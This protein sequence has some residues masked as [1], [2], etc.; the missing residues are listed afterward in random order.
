MWYTVGKLVVESGASAR[1]EV[2]W[3]GRWTL[4]EKRA[5]GSLARI[6]GG[7][8]DAV[9]EL[10]MQAADVGAARG[11]DAARRAQ[12]DMTLR[13]VNYTGPYPFAEEHHD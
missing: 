8:D 7:L 9:F 4:Y 1:G 10:P 2:K 12:G 3:M 6:D 13:A 5:D 11:V